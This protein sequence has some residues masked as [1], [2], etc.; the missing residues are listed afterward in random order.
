MRFLMFLVAVCRPMFDLVLH[1]CC[2]VASHSLDS[3]DWLVFKLQVGSRWWF[4]KSMPEIRCWT[5]WPLCPYFSK[6][7]SAMTFASWQLGKL[8]GREGFCFHSPFQKWFFRL[9]HVQLPSVFT[10]VRWCKYLMKSSDT[11]LP[12]S[13]RYHRCQSMAFSTLF[14]I[15]SKGNLRKV[16]LT[17]K[18]SGPMRAVKLQCLVEGLARAMQTPMWPSWWTSPESLDGVCWLKPK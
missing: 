5:M 13:L 8:T 4:R 10:G 17:S 18:T 1:I 3:W 9:A 11:L 2:L 7:F 14:R 6:N 16:S 12:E 15:Q